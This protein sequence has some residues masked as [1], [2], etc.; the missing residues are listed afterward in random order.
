MILPAVHLFSNGFLYRDRHVSTPSSD[1]TTYV[2]EDLLNPKNTPSSQ[3]VPMLPSGRLL[4]P[5]VGSL[6][7]THSP[8]PRINW[9]KLLPFTRSHGVRPSELLARALSSVHVCCRSHGT[10]AWLTGTYWPNL[11]SRHSLRLLNKPL[12]IL[13]ATSIPPFDWES[14]AGGLSV[15]TFFKFLYSRRM[16]ATRSFNDRTALSLSDFRTT[17][18]WPSHSMSAATN[19]AQ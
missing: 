8:K 1:A 9:L 3:R 12:T 19:F 18:V 2:L 11:A 13:I 5:F 17:L 15:C 14:Y 4:G 16:R 7:S 10:R 6:Y